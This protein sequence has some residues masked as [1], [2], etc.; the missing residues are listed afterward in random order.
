[1]SKILY[2]AEPFHVI[3]TPKSYEIYQAE[4]V[5][6]KRRATIGKTLPDAWARVLA[7]IARRQKLVTTSHQHPAPTE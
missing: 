7:E 2:H 3:D 4:G 6:S 1:M 5:A